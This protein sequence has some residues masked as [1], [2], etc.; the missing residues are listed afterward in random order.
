VCELPQCSY[1]TPGSNG[2]CRVSLDDECFAYTY[3]DTDNITNITIC[4]PECPSGT[5]AD[6]DSSGSTTGL[7]MNLLNM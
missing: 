7:H 6:R 3:K 4:V 1:R 2:L 5:E